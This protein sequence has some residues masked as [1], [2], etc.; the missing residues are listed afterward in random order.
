MCHKADSNTESPSQGDHPSP[1]TLGWLL[2]DQI[3]LAHESHAAQIRLWWEKKKK[4]EKRSR[5]DN[6]NNGSSSKGREIAVPSVL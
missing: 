4:R 5:G 6:M 1:L 3:F 2:S